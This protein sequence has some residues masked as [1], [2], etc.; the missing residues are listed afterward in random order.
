MTATLLSARNVSRRFGA[1]LALDGVSLD[2]CAGEVHAIVGENGAGKST[3]LNVLSG[4]LRPDD[5]QIEIE[6]RPVAFASPR[7]ARALGIATVFQELSLAGS[8]SIAENIFA[9]RTPS[10]F[11]LVEWARLNRQAAAT[12]AGLGVAVD[13]RR[14]LAEASVSLR[15]MVE[16]AKAISADARILLLDE[17]TA[18]LAT[19]EAERLFET[20]A[21]LKARGIGIVY[22][23]H[24]LS[25]VLRIAD[26][27][28]VLRD[29]RVVATREARGTDQEQ[30][31]RDMVGRELA[32]WTRER[33]RAR[34]AVL[35]DARGLGR[36]GAFRDVSLQLAAG[37]IVGLAGLM[38]SFRSEL[39]RALCGILRPTAGEIRLR[40]EPIRW[41]SIADAM[42]RRVA[43]VPA[44]RKTDG[45]FLDL[46]LAENVTVAAAAKIS[47]GGL[48]SCSR[49]AAAARR[50]I[51]RLRIKAPGPAVRVG[52]LSGGNQ[53]K[54]L[55]A[56]FLEIGPEVLIVEEPT[57]GVDVGSKREIHALLAR[58]AEDGAAI[59][60]ISSDLVEL[61]GICDRIL[62][63]HAGRIAGELGAGE[64]SEEAIVALASGLPAAAER[65]A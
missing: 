28:T 41:A 53:Q 2:L 40:G 62:V 17:P 35:L 1:T 57:R 25:E 58:L 43:Y 56:R 21:A 27:V 5:G 50:A 11:G 26:R 24:H 10:R 3:L 32:G 19:A 13:V 55:L 38:G 63:M 7:D 46:S 4:V 22:I 47:R 14:P 18:A 36:A 42:R 65:A 8:V 59:L 15:Q 6:G 29:G 54:T 48:F 16:I 23:S 34:G 64:A 51:E 20:I 44:E 31:V 37:E 33:R 52:A 30:L 12:L 61:I 49:A 39:G 45:L 9:G 60:L